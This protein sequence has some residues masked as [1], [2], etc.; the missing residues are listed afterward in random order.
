MIDIEPQVYAQ[1]SARLRSVYGSDIAIYGEYVATPVKYPATTIEQKSNPVYRRTRTNNKENHV[2][3]MFEVNIL[4]NKTPGKK[5][6]CKEIAKI[7]D[8]VFG[9]LGFTRTA[10]DPIPNLEDLTIYRMVGRYTAIVSA[11][12]YII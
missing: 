7:I 10:L 5:A 9:E 12:E 1:V 3:T 11:D 4:S 2:L 6:E 8:E